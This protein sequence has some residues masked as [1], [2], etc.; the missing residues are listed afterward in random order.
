MKRIISLVLSV[1]LIAVFMTA[2]GESNTYELPVLDVSSP[3]S[4]SSEEQAPAATGVS[5][6][7]QGE[8]DGYVFTESET[9]TN[10][11]KIEMTTGDIMIAELYPN[12]APITVANFKKLTSEKFYDGIIFHRVISSFV[13]QG[14]DPDG[15]G[16]GGSKENIKGEFTQ[17]GV[18]NNIPHVRG[19]LSMARRGD[20]MDSA[21]SQFFIV[22]QTSD[23]NSASLD[24][25][26][27]AFG[28]LI[29]GWD[30][31]DKIANCKVNGESPVTKQIM[32][33]V[34]FV[35]VTPKSEATVSGEADVQ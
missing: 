20:D 5:K 13:I 12:D 28:K 2:C 18:T 9:E 14:G 29:A 3:S 1:L 33:T 22:T 6:T 16:T 7:T 19:T 30:T 27:A 11:V 31:L 8:L 21:S 34:R 4:T 35:T 10:F 32:N 25:G 26:Y 17:N 24:G 23:N 15:N